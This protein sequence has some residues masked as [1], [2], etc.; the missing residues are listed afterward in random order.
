M[1]ARLQT[2]AVRVQISPPVPLLRDKEK[3]PLK[4]KGGE[5][6]VYSLLSKGPSALGPKVP[7]PSRCSVRDLRSWFEASLETSPP[8]VYRL[9]RWVLNPER[10][11]QLRWGGLFT[12]MRASLADVRR[13]IREAWIDQVKG[14]LAD[15][16]VPSDFNPVELKLGIQDELEHTDDEDVATEIAM[17]HLTQDPEYYS[18]RLSEA[19]IG[20]YWEEA[21]GLSKRMGH[22]PVQVIRDYFKACPQTFDVFVVDDL[23]LKQARH[24]FQ[25]FSQT[26]FPV[27]E[28][29]EVAGLLP[30]LAGKLKADTVSVVF[31]RKLVQDLVNLNTRHPAWIAHDIGHGL[32]DYAS[33]HAEEINRVLKRLEDPTQSSALRRLKDVEGMIG[34]PSQVDR[35]IVR[36]D[37]APELLVNFIEH[38]KVSLQAGTHLP[39]NARSQAEAQLEQALLNLLDEVKGKVVMVGVLPSGMVDLIMRLGGDPWEKDP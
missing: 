38:G 13:L 20:E 37:F 31:I 11:V 25:N 23:T 10:A 27:A 17:D 9:G 15:R 7:S 30:Q 4:P 34:A 35:D 39:A 14:G 19:P 24:I 6:E 2:V 1:S 22:S 33:P 29:A 12:S 28:R 26:D 8:L 21:P 18:K 3:I 16:K 32:L 5:Q 36:G